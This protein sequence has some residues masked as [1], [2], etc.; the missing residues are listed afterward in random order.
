M[1]VSNSYLKSKYLVFTINDIIN[2]ALHQW[3]QSRR[4]ELNLFSVSF[5]SELPPDE[6]A[7]ALVFVEQQIN[8]ENGLSVSNIKNF[9][10]DF[11]EKKILSILKKFQ[12]YQLIRSHKVNNQELFYAIYP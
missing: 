7:I 1:L 3:I 10:N 2:E 6:K 11:D 8:F 4:N 9:L 12:S 5:R